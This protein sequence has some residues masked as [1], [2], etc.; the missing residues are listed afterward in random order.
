MDRHESHGE[1]ISVQSP[2]RQVRRMDNGGNDVLHLL[3]SITALG[4]T[5]HRK[6]V[7]LQQ[8]RID[9]SIHHSLICFFYNIFI[10][11]IILHYI[12]QISQWLLHQLMMARNAV[13][14]IY[15]T[16]LYCSCLSR[17]LDRCVAVVNLVHSYT[18]FKPHLYIISW[19]IVFLFWIDIYT[20]AHTHSL[21]LFRFLVS[22]CRFTNNLF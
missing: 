22:C 11:F 13:V 12:T 9:V 4:T 3:R 7:L 16:L 20:H 1:V 18:Q 2:Q 15:A 8:Q 17:L 19:S 21:K 5:V 14:A 10:F 6:P